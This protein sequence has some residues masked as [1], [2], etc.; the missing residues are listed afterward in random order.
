MTPEEFRQ[1]A[2][3]TVDW[4]ADFLAGVERYPVLPHVKPGELTD[5]PTRR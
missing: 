1:H 5:A 4:V 3:K 2:H